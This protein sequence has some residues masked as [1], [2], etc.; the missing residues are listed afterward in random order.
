[1]EYTLFTSTL[2]QPEAYDQELASYISNVLQIKNYTVEENEF[3]VIPMTTYRFPKRE[4]NIVHIGTAGGQTKGSSG[5]TFYF[6]QQHSKA[7]AESLARAGH[8]FVASAPGRFRFYD[9]VLLQVLA[10]NEI[11]GKEIFTTMFK[12]NKPQNVLAFL[13]NASSLSTEV[14][15]IST[16][17]TLPF[18]KAALKQVL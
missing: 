13:N 12:K 8:P 11:E 5:Y 18:L 1:V 16:L 9:N 17:P 15:L 6:I 14:G 3:G 7:I 2:L 10:Q 4:N